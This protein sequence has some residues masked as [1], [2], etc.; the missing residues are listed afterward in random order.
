MER[1]ASEEICAFAKKSEIARKSCGESAQRFTFLMKFRFK[2]LFSL[3]Q[4]YFQWWWSQ[5]IIITVA[6]HRH[7]IVDSACNA[8]YV[9]PDK[10]LRRQSENQSP[11]WCYQTKEKGIFSRPILNKSLK[12]GDIRCI[13]SLLASRLWHCDINP[14]TAPPPPLC[15]GWVVYLGTQKLHQTESC[16]SAKPFILLGHKVI[17]CHSF[18]WHYFNN[19]VILII[20]ILQSHHDL[21]W[22]NNF[23]Q[24]T[25]PVLHEIRYSGLTLIYGFF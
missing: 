25:L 11:R 18:P 3:W 17:F 2:S 16:V 22:F 14:D 6:G 8:L 21:G 13:W 20:A 10:T 23:C 5:I 12:K 9:F 19:L 4:W 15:P 7:I 1:G 24:L